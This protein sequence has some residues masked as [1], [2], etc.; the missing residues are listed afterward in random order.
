M[1][2]FTP[3]PWRYESD[4][5]GRR[6]RGGEMFLTPIAYPAEMNPG[7]VTPALDVVE[8]N[9]RLAAAAPE[10]LAQL[11]NALE[12]IKACGFGGSNVRLERK[13]EKALADL[14]EKADP[15]ERDAALEVGARVRV[16]RF[17]K[18]HGGKAGEVREVYDNGTYGV[19]LDLM[20]DSRLP[21]LKTYSRVELELLAPVDALK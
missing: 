20:R 21:H 9:M 2:K 19:W 1:A 7:G 5:H 15:F 17:A 6:I 11:K 18:P 14:I 12:V 4:E 3:G 10:M 13:M 8:A 16:A